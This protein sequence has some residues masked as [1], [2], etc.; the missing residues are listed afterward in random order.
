MEGSGVYRDHASLI[1]Q[2]DQLGHG[3]R[4]HLLHDPPPMHLDR[5][6]A[7]A[8]VGG[9]L[10][11]QPPGDDEGKDLSLPRSLG[12]DAVVNVRG[13]GLLPSILKGLDRRPLDGSQELTVIDGLGEKIDS[14]AL[15][16][17]D[18]ARDIG[19]A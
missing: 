16:G 8:K 11:V 6:L 1:G 5:L 15:H 3:S 2:S 13:D 4:S 7:D 10:L 18:A 17:L 12:L 14:P 9:N 19:V